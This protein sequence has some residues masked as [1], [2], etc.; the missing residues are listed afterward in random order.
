MACVLTIVLYAL[1]GVPAILLIL[2]FLFFYSIF[3]Y[4][5]FKRSAISIIVENEK[6]FIRQGVDAEK[7]YAI[8]GITSFTISR[9][10]FSSMKALRILEWFFLKPKNPTQMTMVTVDGSESL[11]FS[12]LYG[13]PLKKSWVKFKKQLEKLTKKPVNLEIQNM[14]ND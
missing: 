14:R 9:K 13:S 11:L 8:D 4:G 2:P 3:L 5:T 10:S 1:F 7:E 12:Y 6:V